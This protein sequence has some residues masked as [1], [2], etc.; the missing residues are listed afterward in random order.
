MFDTEAAPL[1]WKPGGL[2]YV[3]DGSLAW[4][5]THAQS[6]RALDLGNDRLRIVFSTRDQKGRTRPGSIDVSASDPSVIQAIAKDPLLELGEPGAF[7]DCGVMPAC[8]LRSGGK[9]YLFYTGWNTSQTVPYRLSIGLACSDDGGLSF[10]KIGRGPVMD[11]SLHEPLGCSQPYVI[12]WGN[13]FRMYYL[14]IFKWAQVEGRLESYY[15]LRYVDSDNL[16]HW[17]PKGDVAVECDDDF[18]Q[19]I[20]VPTVWVENGGFRMIYCFRGDNRFR[21]DPQ[22]AYRLGFAVSPDGDQ[23]RRQ[24]DRIGIQ[25]STSGW[26][27][28]MQAYPDYFSH[29]LGSYLFYSGNGFG[30]GGFGFARR[31]QKG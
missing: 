6:P 19:A 27:S 25:R 18:T 12:P 30:R 8:F 9:I 1:E 15:N 4:S 10:T 28:E 21:T 13:G 14:S 22:S 11:R 29:P 2:I 5:K 17:L 16:L 23:W 26:D 20:A 31:V 24:D 7:D 3:P